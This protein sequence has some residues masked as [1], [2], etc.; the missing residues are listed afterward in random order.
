MSRTFKHKIEGKFNNDLIELS[1]V[2]NNVRKKWD[3][4]NY[5]IG[6]FRNLRNK[7]RYLA[8]LFC[9]FLLGCNPCRYVAKH[10]ECVSPDTI[11]QVE[12]VVHTEKEYIIKDSISYDTIKGKDILIEKTI[13][14]TKYSHKIDT[15]YSNK[16]IDRLNPINEKLKAENDKLTIKTQVLKKQRN[17]LSLSMSV[18]IILIAVYLIVKRYLIKI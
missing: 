18:L 1:E 10:P 9:L 12:R 8:I 2:P 15:I 5:D 13:F 3:R 6:Y 17:I 14:Q 4:H 11:K 16:V 7:K